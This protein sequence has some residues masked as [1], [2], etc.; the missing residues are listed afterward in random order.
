MF[1]RK[2]KVLFRN[3]KNSRVLY[4][5]YFF[6]DTETTIFRRLSGHVWSKIILLRRPNR[7]CTIF[8]VSQKRIVAA[9]FLEY[10][11]CTD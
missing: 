8:I 6:T 1:V 10:F 4:Y 11:K 5:K 7:F 2:L 3:V 9:Y